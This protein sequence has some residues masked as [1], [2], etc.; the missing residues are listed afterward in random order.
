MSKR[1]FLYGGAILWTIAL[2][3]V[4]SDRHVTD[5]VPLFESVAVRFLVIL[6]V[7]VALGALVRAILQR[8]RSPR[9]GHA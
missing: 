9:P 7:N 5:Q 2:F 6:A 4:L 3:I 8:R 1:I